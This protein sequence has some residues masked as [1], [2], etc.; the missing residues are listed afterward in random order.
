M[1]REPGEAA[2]CCHCFSRDQREL[3]PERLCS[4]H[5]PM[6]SFD[7]GLRNPAW[8]FPLSPHSPAPHSLPLTSTCYWRA[9]RFLNLTVTQ[10]L[11]P[12]I[13]TALQESVP[14]PP[15]LSCSSLAFSDSPACVPSRVYKGRRERKASRGQRAPELNQETEE[16]CGFGH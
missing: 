11:F 4:S 16:L 9:E 8:P 14:I 7:W 1:G 3:Q 13:V 10:S 6:A 12:S 2:W 15:I 5:P